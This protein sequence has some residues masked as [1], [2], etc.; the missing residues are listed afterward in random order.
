MNQLLLYELEQNLGQSK[1]TSN[2]NFAFHCPKCKTSH[3]E[4]YHKKKLEIDIIS[5][6][7]NCWICR[8][9]GTSLSSLYK[10]LKLDTTNLQ[11]YVSINKNEKDLIQ[12]L[13][14]INLPN[15]YNF[16]GEFPN[17][18]YEKYLTKRGINDVDIWKYRIGYCE[19]GYFKNRIIVPSFDT[20]GLVNN[21][22][23]RTISKD[24]DIWTYLKPKGVDEDNIIN[25][26]LLVNWNK[27]VIL[28]EGSFDAISIGDN[29]IPLFGKNVSTKLLQKLLD[30]NSDKIYVC[31]DKDALK[32]SL[33]IAENLMRFGKNVYFVELDDKDP[34]QI[35]KEKMFDIINNTEK[36]DLKGIIKLKLQ[37]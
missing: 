26:E 17:K 4:H 18:K 8:F 24:K 14:K 11:K 16:L 25:F 37:I 1:H 3:P 23:A 21:F 10:S 22:V 36:L 2:S 12:I 9:K 30:S 29:A 5:E 19:Y 15:E 34:N 32:N 7:F 13:P 35:G 33:R 31:L 6:R 20:N 28:C 27:P